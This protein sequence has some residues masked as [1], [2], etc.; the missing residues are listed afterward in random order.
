VNPF[1]FRGGPR[2]FAELGLPEEDEGWPL[3]AKD[4]GEISI[5]AVEGLPGGGPESE[6]LT[7]LWKKA[8]RP[9]VDP[10]FYKGVPLKLRVPEAQLSTADVE[11]MVEVGKVEVDPTQKG[12]AGAVRMR[13]IAEE[14]KKRFGRLDGRVT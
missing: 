2:D 10:E 4:V 5:E 6:H 1:E 7:E 3:H 12:V 13:K 14:A 8:M 9:L 11:K